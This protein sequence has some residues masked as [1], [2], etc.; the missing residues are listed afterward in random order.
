M[1]KLPSLQFF[2]PQMRTQLTAIQLTFN[3]YVFLVLTIPAIHSVLC[4]LFRNKRFALN[5]MFQQNASKFAINIDQGIHKV[6]I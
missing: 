6:K 2:T 1:A 3:I 5:V 4:S